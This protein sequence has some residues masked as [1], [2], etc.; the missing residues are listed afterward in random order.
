MSSVFSLKM[1]MS[2]RS[3]RLTGDGTPWNQRT[4]RRQTYRSR[5][6]RS[7]TFSERNPPP[8]GVVRGPLIPIRYSRKA[9]SVSSGNQFPVCFER[10]LPGEHLGPGD[11]VPV[12]GDGGVDDALGRRPDV[13]ARA[14]AFYEWD[15]GLVGDPELAV[16]PHSYLV[17]HGR[18]PRGGRGHRTSA[19]RSRARA[20][21][22]PLPG[23][24]SP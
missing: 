19:P 5:I 12:L 6:W 1:T 10:L 4:G 2:T 17:S 20:G 8:T 18:K 24:N 14:V 22:V 21:P 11:L 7:A 16:G 23:D 9:A 3:G 13:H 15:D